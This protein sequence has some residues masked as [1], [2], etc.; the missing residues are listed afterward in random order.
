MERDVITVTP[1]T[2]IL[3]VHRLFVE[4]EITD[5]DVCMAAYTQ[6]APLHAIPVVNVMAKQV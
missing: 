4:E 1:E 2:R 5:R 6:G 3:D